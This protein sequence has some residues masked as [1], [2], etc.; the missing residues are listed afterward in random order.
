[1]LSNLQMRKLLGSLNPPEYITHH[2]ERI[3][4][5]VGHL[6]RHLPLS[7]LRA[8]DLGHDRHVGVLLAQCGLEV[9]GNVL[10]PELAGQGLPPEQTSSFV[11]P[12]GDAL[13]WELCPFDFEERFPFDDCSFDLVTALEV[14]E[15]IRD[16]PR[17]VLREI[18]RV[19]KKSG[20]LYIS[21]PNICSISKLLRCFHHGNPYDA[22]PYSQN[23]G[24]RHCMCHV[25]EY[26]PWELRELVKS[27]GFEVVSLETWNPYKDD[28]N[29]LRSRFIQVLFSMSL[30]AAGYAKAGLL[31]YRQRGHQIGLLAKKV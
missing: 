1:M 12:N 30:L 10:P 21:T 17:S 18:R 4:T 2:L 14:V 11:L 7:G 25:Y 5:C 24:P 16:N 6:Q 26:S 29:P 15:H 31:A 27:E 23:F 8:L 28:P 13:Q 20:H 19:L 9:C 22:K 3:V